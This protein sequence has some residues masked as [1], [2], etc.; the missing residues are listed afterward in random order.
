MNRPQDW[1]NPVMEATW[2]IDGL[3]SRDFVGWPPYQSSDRQ[4][5]IELLVELHPDLSLA[6][7]RLSGRGEFRESI[8]VLMESVGKVDG[9]NSI[10]IAFSFSYLGAG[11]HGRR[12]ILAGCHSEYIWLFSAFFSDGERRPVP[13]GRMPHGYRIQRLPQ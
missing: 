7:W 2:K 6:A 4:D 3:F 8:S 12:S 9:L 11:N 1:P 13:R 10:D 5:G